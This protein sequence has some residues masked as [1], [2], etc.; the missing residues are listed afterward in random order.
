MQQKK[1]QE[2][3]PYLNK[4]IGAV[5]VLIKGWFLWHSLETDLFITYYI[6]SY[7]ICI[8]CLYHIFY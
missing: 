2:K 8:I 6:Y 5:G 1:K 3:K 7:I 4:S